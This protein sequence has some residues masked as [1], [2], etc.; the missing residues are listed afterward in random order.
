MKLKPDCGTLPWLAAALTILGAAGRIFL[1]TEP[2]WLTYLFFGVVAALALTIAYFGW[3]CHVER[4]LPAPHIRKLIVHL[5]KKKGFSGTA[6]Q[7][8]K[9]AQQL[10]YEQNFS[11][12]LRESTDY[13]SFLIANDYIKIVGASNIGQPDSGLYIALTDKAQKLIK[14]FGQRDEA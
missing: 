9:E 13:Y 14:T 7:F 3:K 6:A 12:H 2:I 10:L 4:Q 8:N 5:A 11:Q 1:P